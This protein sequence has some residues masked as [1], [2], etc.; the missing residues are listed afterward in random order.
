MFTPDEEYAMFHPNPSDKFYKC[1]HEKS[2]WRCR[3][4]PSTGCKA[5]LVTAFPDEIDE[6]PTFTENM[7][8]QMVTAC[9]SKEICPETGKHHW[10]GYFVAVNPKKKEGWMGFLKTFNNGKTVHEVAIRPSLAYRSEKTH[11]TAKNYCGAGDF[12]KDGKVK[13]ANDTYMEIKDDISFGQQGSRSDLAAIKEQLL[14]GRSYNDIAELE[15]SLEDIAKFGHAME[16]VENIA[17][18]KKKRDFQ[19]HGVWFHGAEGTGKSHMAHWFMETFFEGEYFRVSDDVCAKGWW[20]AYNGE[21]VIWWDEAKGEIEHKTLMSIVD[22]FPYDLPIR[23]KA[24]V[25]CLAK[26]FVVS[27]V[28]SPESAYAKYLSTAVSGRLGE[29]RRRFDVIDLGS[30]PMDQSA[31][32]ELIDNW[33]LN[34]DTSKR[35][36]NEDLGGGAMQVFKKK[37]TRDEEVEQMTNSMDAFVEE[38]NQW[39]EEVLNDGRETPD[40]QTDFNKRKTNAEKLRTELE[41]EEMEERAYDSEP[42]DAVGQAMADIS[43][44]PVRKKPAERPRKRI[45]PSLI[46]ACAPRVYGPEFS[47]M[48]AVGENELELID[49]SQSD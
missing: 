16:T 13:E 47:Q 42:E 1:H 33:T 12:E 39:Q 48:M 32:Q 2:P 17:R 7:G 40:Y 45:K 11:E 30:T 27:S 38:V 4:V 10:Q 44:K 28:A 36:E 3:D 49:L 31:S 14:G 37:D 23:G 19:C 25:P 26:F 43:E 21:P 15:L 41:H 5:V 9:W 24:P 35:T 18:R 46:P 8:K 20:D 34:D 22:K 6:E 29:L